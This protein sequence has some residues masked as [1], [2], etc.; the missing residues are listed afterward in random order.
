MCRAT[1]VGAGFRIDS[2]VNE[3]D[4]YSSVHKL[5]ERASAETHEC[6]YARSA[7][8]IPGFS[9]ALVLFRSKGSLKKLLLHGEA[10]IRLMGLQP[11][12]PTRKALTK[13]LLSG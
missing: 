3:F 7:S 13:E 9:K 5:E 2:R 4:K 1:C 12:Q 8:W 10:I 11:E 6:G